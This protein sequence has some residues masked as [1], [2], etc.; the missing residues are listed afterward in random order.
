MT[1]LAPDAETRLSF[2]TASALLHNLGTDPAAVEHWVALGKATGD[3]CR[4]RDCHE[5]S[6]ALGMCQSHYKRH[7]RA[8]ANEAALLNRDA[9]RS[10]AA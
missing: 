6:D 2:L 8:V 5:H 3:V 10:S 1:R 4:I 7:N 9:R